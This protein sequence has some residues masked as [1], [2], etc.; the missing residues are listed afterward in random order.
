[1]SS[2]QSSGPRQT[3]ARMQFALRTVARPN[4]IVLVWRWRYELMLA[5]GVTVGVV[6]LAGWPLL[7]AAVVIAL[8]TIWPASRQ[9]LIARAWCVV[10]PHRVRTACAQ[11]WIHSRT[12]KIPII[13]LT[14]P[15]PF[16]ERVRLWCRAGTSAE[17]FISARQ[18]LVAACWAEDVLVT[19][20]ER[21]AQL[22]TLDVIRHAQRKDQDEP[23]TGLRASTFRSHQSRRPAGYTLTN[24]SGHRG[25]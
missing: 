3:L 24:P 5:A 23:G 15:Q 11:A 18:L 7:G 9:P 19:R 25:K 16:G 14:T 22:V 2:E 21:S 17:D 12:G 6:T 1:M 4:L 13:L 8:A 20:S 10:T